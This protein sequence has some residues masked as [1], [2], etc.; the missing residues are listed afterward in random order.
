MNNKT[1]KSPALRCEA[2]VSAPMVEEPDESVPPGQYY[3][4]FTGKQMVWTD[5]LGWVEH[6]AGDIP[7]SPNGSHEPRGGKTNE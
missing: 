2:M 7:E 5:D 6:K 4:P 1:N 3:D